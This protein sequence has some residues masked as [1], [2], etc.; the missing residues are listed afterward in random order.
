MKVLSSKVIVIALS[1]ALLLVLGCESRASEFTLNTISSDDRGF[2]TI[3][4]ISLRGEVNPL[5]GLGFGFDGGLTYHPVDKL[6]YAISRNEENFSTIHQISLNGAVTPLFGLGHGFDGGLIY[7]HI[8]KRLYAISRDEKGYSTLYR[9]SKSGE[10][11]PLFGL[12]FGFAGLSHDLARDVFYAIATDEGGFSTLHSIS[13]SGAVQPL[14]GLGLRFRGGLA[15]HP[16]K[17]LLY[18]ISSNST[19]FSMLHEISLSGTVRPLFGLGYGFN[20][21]TLTIAP[22][23]PGSAIW[24]HEPL[25]NERFVV[26][27]SVHFDAVVTLESATE[28]LELPD[29]SELQWH[30]D[31]DGL[32]GTGASIAVTNLSVGSHIITASG[33]GVSET[34]PIRIFHDL[35]ELY[36]AHPAPAEITRIRNHFTFDWFDGMEDDE[37]WAPY[38]SFDFDQSSTDP[39]K[40]V[41]M[42]KLDLLR[43]Q[44]FS[45]PLPM[46]N[47]ETIYNHF[48]THVHTIRLRLDCGSNRGSGGWVNLNRGLSV[49]H[50]KQGSGS[51][52]DACKTPPSNPLL[53]LYIV[54]LQLLVHEG[55]HS[56]PDDPNHSDCSEGGPKDEDLELEDG[57]G[58]AWGALYWMWVYKYSLYDPPEM[59]DWA[60]R[61]A[62]Q[63]LRGRFC[64]PP[65]HSDPKVQAIVDELLSD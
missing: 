31:I 52:P 30:S 34:F 59:K 32:V 55:R 57:S 54:Q 10:A 39:S 63:L 21:P 23:V 49:W 6:F 42:A 3:N 1:V 45:E 26:G 12:G 17:R 5:F 65:S 43:H 28:C 40:V 51:D 8:D 9:I 44:E 4:G 53:E 22:S 16:G 46:T 20:A 27:E 61:A 64:T 62:T 14:F 58:Y 18:G 56:E 2:S 50:S 13:L 19:G 29:G 11:S 41:I 25:R 47:G 35:L 60:K 33:Y 38:D 7:R 15:Y 36:Q 48:R 37:L 24:I